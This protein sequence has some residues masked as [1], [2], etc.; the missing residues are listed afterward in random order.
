MLRNVI[1][2]L[3]RVNVECKWKFDLSSVHDATLLA[4]WHISI[5]IVNNT[6]TQV[7]S[8]LKQNS[9]I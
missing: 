6:N 2:N 5:T 4:S 9:L 7:N 3:Q 8:Q 1:I